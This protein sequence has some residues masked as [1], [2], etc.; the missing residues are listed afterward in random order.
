M[1]SIISKH[2]MISMSFKHVVLTGFDV[3]VLCLDVRYV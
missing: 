1:E 3:Y 2:E